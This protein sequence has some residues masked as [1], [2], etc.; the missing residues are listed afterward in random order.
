MQNVAV[1]YRVA[2]ARRITANGFGK[3]NGVGNAKRIPALP[4]RAFVGMLAVGGLWCN[5][6]F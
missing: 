6:L 1:F 3:P 2:S 4:L 5:A